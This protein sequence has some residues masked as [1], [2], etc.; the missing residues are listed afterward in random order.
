MYVHSV[1]NK[2]HPVGLYALSNSVTHQPI[3]LVRFG[4]QLPEETW[5][6]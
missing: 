2:R 6:K 1:S 5:Y 3:I 4:M